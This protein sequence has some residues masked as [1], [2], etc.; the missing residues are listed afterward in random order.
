MLR[1]P[2]IL[3]MGVDMVRLCLLLLLVLTVLRMRSV[4][5]CFVVRQARHRHQRHERAGSVDKHASTMLLH[6]NLFQPAC[7]PGAAC[8]QLKRRLEVLALLTHRST[9]EAAALVVE[10]PSLL[11]CGEAVLA[12]NAR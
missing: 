10:Y 6:Y 12:D 11:G 2:R 8:V 3:L 5:G 7:R 9:R 4:V 1:S